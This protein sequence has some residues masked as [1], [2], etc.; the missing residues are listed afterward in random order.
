M[1]TLNGNA[2]ADNI[3]DN[4]IAQVRSEILASRA[5]RIANA[6]KRL[7][8]ADWKAD[9]TVYYEA[10]AHNQHIVSVLRINPEDD[11]YP[12]EHDYTDCFTV[13]ILFEGDD[14]TT[15]IGTVGYVEQN[16][17]T[18]GYYIGSGQKPARI[19]YL[20]KLENL[21]KL[22]TKAVKI[23]TLFDN[24]YFIGKFTPVTDD[25]GD[26]SLARTHSDME[27]EAIKALKAK[28]QEKA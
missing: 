2:Q 25:N 6:D 9:N 7:L 14:K 22:V 19:Q 5:I 27:L 26:V 21:D 10:G 17:N 4:V 16:N 12:I 1:S 24:E 13:S 20:S 15:K 18:Y 11:N 3:I 23:S 28:E 8:A